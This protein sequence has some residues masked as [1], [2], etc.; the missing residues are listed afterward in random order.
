MM[1][2]F[3]VSLAGRLLQ[4][5]AG[6]PAGDAGC[7]RHGA[8]LAMMRGKDVVPMVRNVAERKRLAANRGIRGV[9]VCPVARIGLIMKE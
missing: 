2:G 5:R 6:F 8:L 4:G 9:G 3:P 7:A 1:R